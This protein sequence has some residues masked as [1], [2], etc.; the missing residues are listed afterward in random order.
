MAR[1]GRGAVVPPMTATGAP[2]EAAPANHGVAPEPIARPG[3]PDDARH[4]IARRVIA[5]TA[6]PFVATLAGRALAWVLAVV[7]A[8]TLGPA[9]TGDYAIAVNL[10]VYA[11]ILADFGLGTWLTREVART[12]GAGDRTGA[13]REVVATTLG[14]R[15]A[16]A[17]VAALAMTA[18]AA[19]ARA[20]G[21][22]G[23]DLAWTMV[24]L[25]AGL[26]P[27]AVAAAAS[28]TYGAYERMGV[29]AVV[30]VIGAVATTLAG[31]ALLASGAG[32]VGLGATSLAV[33]VATAIAFAALA[34]RDLV[35]LAV[36]WSRAGLV[37]LL[38]DS[39]PLM[40][41]N[42]LNGV[43]FRIDVQVLS[44]WDRA[45]V[46]HY[47]SAYKVI[48][49]VGGISSSFVLALFPLLSRRAGRSD[50]PGAG[51]GRTYA[52]ALTILVTVAMPV[53]VLL[54]WIAAPLSLL[55]W[56]EAFL[57]E[58]AVALQVLIWFLPLSFV[59]GLTQY[60]LIALGLQARITSA[61]ALAAAFNLG[62]NLLL[63]PAYGYVAAAATT[64]ATEAILLIPFARAIATRMP[65]A[66]LA[67]ACVRPLPGVAAATLVL[68][69][70]ATVD[71]WFGTIGAAVAYPLALW[72]TRAFAPEDL[73]MVASLAR[74]Q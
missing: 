2:D 67:V 47:A 43:F 30:S 72:M 16:L 36:A 6:A 10:W 42:L 11:G 37:P 63:V 71:P 29:P 5:N 28:A 13:A 1:V 33:N 56:G 32:I 62:A 74:R 60:V 51:L 25:A 15:L 49:G 44:A 40:L 66:P 57:P 31:T 22:I 48:D 65:L 20:A 7:T 69:A 12:R 55:L 26:L 24:L 4:A 34:R 61:F 41:N 18:I 35:P 59:N 64:I 39:L 70:G 14:V 68:L 38:R 23:T 52:L 58:S 19:V 53:A 3:A 9:G 54:T 73:A 27:G 45:T 8:R 46:G 50:A 21:W 17:S